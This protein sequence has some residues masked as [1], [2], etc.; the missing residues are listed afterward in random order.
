MIEGSGLEKALLAYVQAGGW[1]I[2]SGPPGVYD[3]YGRPD[4]RLLTTLLGPCAPAYVSGDE[5]YWVWAL[6][7]RQPRPEVKVELADDQGA[8]LLVSA[9][10]GKGGIL[11]SMASWRTDAAKAVYYRVLEAAIGNRTAWCDGNGMDLVVRVDAQG[12]RYLFAMNR[13]VDDTVEESVHVEGAFAHPVDL[14]IGKRFP[15]PAVVAQ[16]FTTFRLRLE[17]GDSTVIA[18]Q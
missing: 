11:L 1:L 16:G 8:P 3:P 18:L 4:N 14:G 15:L 13:S 2:C 10:Y 6:N 17:R 9:R 5:N 7:L 12:K